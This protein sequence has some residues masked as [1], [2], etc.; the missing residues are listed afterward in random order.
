M[1]K[2][3]FVLSVVV[4]FLSAYA[5]Q[6]ISDPT[7]PQGFKVTVLATGLNAPKGIVSPLHRAG[8][9]P[10]G[11]FLYVAESGADDIA[12][13]DKAG[14]GASF[15]ASTGVADFPVGVAFFGGPFGN[16][17]YV[18]GA[19]GGGIV[20]IDPSGTV[21][22][23][24]LPTMLI[25]G[26]DFGHGAYGSDLYA[27]EWAAGNIHRVDPLGNAT[28]FANIP[29]TQTRYLKFSHGGAFGTFLFYTDFITGDIHQVDATGVATLFASTGAQSL[30]G[31][32]FS[33]GGA[34][35]HFL[36]AGS[37]QTGDI[38][39]V[40]P[41]G[42]VELWASG[43]TGAADIHFEPGKKGGFT[44]YVS[45]GKNPGHVYAISKE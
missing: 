25:A 42:T 39:R 27:G 32:D 17:L 38:Y 41:D 35:G 15:F 33:P 44:M 10:F 19:F 45:D 18:G 43:F 12:K 11:H 26:L 9:G 7:V 5:I 1:K 2:I 21:A 36:Y 31:F 40:A 3:A 13:V 23:F 24:A 28:L 30:E 29:G 37:L 16:F 34:F 4:L 8:A 14:A 6:A 22:P 20:K